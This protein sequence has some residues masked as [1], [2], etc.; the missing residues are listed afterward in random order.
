M[1]KKQTHKEWRKQFS[2]NVFERDKH[3]CKICGEDK[4]LDAH[5]II[6]RHEMPN[7]GYVVEN[8][9]TLCSLHHL[10][11]EQ[12]HIFGKTNGIE[13]MYPDDLYKL[14]NSSYEIAVKKSNE[15]KS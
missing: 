8:G 11:A 13:G 2:K 15:L 9:I 5:H 4:N 3:K 14:I 6:D 7:G 1:S 10:E 12:Y